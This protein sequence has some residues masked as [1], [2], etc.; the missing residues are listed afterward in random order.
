MQAL[1]VAVCS[2]VV[3]MSAPCR[4]CKMSIS[5]SVTRLAL[6]HISQA[7][8]TGLY[9]KEILFPFSILSSFHHIQTFYFRKIYTCTL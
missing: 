9:L 6:P 7:F 3:S 4:P 8:D 2:L 5:I 1:L